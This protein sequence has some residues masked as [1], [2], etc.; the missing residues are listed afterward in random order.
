VA[1]L[2]FDVTSVKA[3]QPENVAPSR[4]TADP[5]RLRAESISLGALIAYAYRVQP[6]QIVDLKSEWGLYDVEGKAD[7]AHSPAELRV[8]LQGLLAERF[9]LK[10]HREMRELPVERLVIG[11]DLKLKATELAEADPHGFTLRGSDRGPN[12][13][14]ANASAISLEWL[15]DS[16]SGKLSKLVVDGTGLK[17]LF[18]FDVDFEFDTAYVADKSVPFREARNHIWERLISGLGL[19]LQS[20]KKA[21]VEVLVI[22]QVQR[23]EAN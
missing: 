21:Q 8:M 1:P 17:G 6:V 18:E 19:K 11:K 10:F 16:L 5:E 3:V 20:D 23:P 22:D 4:I 7:G 14:R 13:L 15:A 9:R 12:F 2:Q